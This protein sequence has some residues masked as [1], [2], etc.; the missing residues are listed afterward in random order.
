MIRFAC[1]FALLS[2]LALASG[3]AANPAHTLYSFTGGSD[4]TVPG[5]GLVIGPG[6][7]AYG[8]TQWGGTGCPGHIDGCGTIYK[9]TPDGT[10]SVLHAFDLTEGRYPRGELVLDA[11][12]NL[13]GAAFEGGNGKN[14]PFEGGCG[15]VFKLA[16]DGTLTKL[17][18][19]QGHLDCSRPAGGLVADASGNLYG[20]TESGGFNR[21]ITGYGCVYKI[22]TDGTY[23]ILY[24][25]Q[26]GADGSNPAGPLAIDG[27]G[28]LYGVTSGIGGGSGS[29]FK[30]TPEGTKTTLYVFTGGPGDGSQP[31]NGVVRDGAGN[32]YA[33]TY[34]GGASNFGTVVKLASGGVESVLHHFAGGTDGTYPNGNLAIDA[35]GNLY[36]VT[37]LGGGPQC[38]G[39]G[40]GTVFK[41]ASD[42]TYSQLHVFKRH[43]GRFPI[44][45]PAVNR[46]GDVLG[47][48]AEG[49]DAASGTIFKIK[50]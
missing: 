44:G 13:F 31:S 48:T 46:H 38:N 33:A 4:G 16:T 36:G 11:D 35:G 9:F 7:V 6:R 14:C 41:I 20:A 47:T 50:N 5:G 27:D 42:G 25:F 28:N 17:H 39:N 24:A 45:A 23:S 2:T 29:I 43:A 49:G 1:R 18:A 22:A 26:G 19:F 12:G 21:H 8:V 32:L 37:Q 10:Q 15:S 40:C 34:N 3:A 30:L